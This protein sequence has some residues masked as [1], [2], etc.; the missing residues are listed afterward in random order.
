MGQASDG[1]PP[2]AD[3][4]PIPKTPDLLDTHSFEAWRRQC[5]ET[6]NLP[7]QLLAEKLESIGS[8]IAFVRAAIILAPLEQQRDRAQTLAMR[9]LEATQRDVYLLA[10][11]I[12]AHLTTLS[13]FSRNPDP[14]MTA[15]SV[16]LMINGIL[17]DARKMTSR[18]PL[19]LE[20]EV[21]AHQALAEAYI[22][23]RKYNRAKR[24]AAEALL[25][26]PHLGLDL[27]AQGARYQLANIAYYEGDLFAAEET[28]QTLTSGPIFSAALAQSST[29]ARAITLHWLGDDD[30]AIACT[31]SGDFSPTGSAHP[32]VEAVRLLSLRYPWNEH[33][34]NLETSVPNTLAHAV[35][36]YR[37]IHQALELQPDHPQEI[38]ATYR[39]ARSEIHKLRQADG[40]RLVHQQVLEAFIS[41]RADEVW[42]ARHKL[43]NFTALETAP[44]LIRAFGFAVA[45]EIA[46]RLLPDETEL[47]TRAVDGLIATVE[48]LSDT[49]RGEQVSRRMQLLL[50][51]STA[52]AARFPECPSVLSG[53]GLEATMNLQ[54][55]PISVYGE[56]SLRPLQAAWFTLKAFDRELPPFDRLGG[57]QFE[58]MRKALYRRY[59]ERDYWFTPV[60]PAQVI[61][62][63]NCCR[64]LARVN[65]SARA[66]M[67]EQAAR[68]TKRDFG[69]IPKLQQVDQLPSLV[70]LEQ[71]IG[72]ASGSVLGLEGTAVVPRRR[73]V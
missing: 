58:A 46:T 55:R 7:R 56:S 27:I 30:A 60:A 10:K 37:F 20:V 62:A 16:T 29:L 22:L 35:S 21:R 50:P 45:S 24:H 59:F 51:L 48:E 67:F 47:L 39:A 13:G 8:E 61:Y 71:D 36:C 65:G 33:F 66:R 18:S 52:I 9:G 53:V 70:Q 14:A 12:C 6:Q 26:A 68:E 25:L 15:T 44:P 49:S 23:G 4:P 42:L 57:G 54:Q 11:L 28:Y 19:L 5:L 2:S 31:N 40:W 64:H 41:L 1:Q 43:P 72:L 34:T 3:T 32:R 73:I 38:Q 63:L 69:V 17:E